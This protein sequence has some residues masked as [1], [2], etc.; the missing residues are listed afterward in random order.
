R[1]ARPPKREAAPGP[2][3]ER[4]RRAPNQDATPVEKPPAGAEYHWRRLP[5]LP[6]PCGSSAP[7]A[8][9]LRCPIIRWILSSHRLAGTP[10]C[11]LSPVGAAEPPN[12]V[13]RSG[14]TL[15]CPPRINYPFALRPSAP[16]GA[17]A[18]PRRGESGNHRRPTDS[19]RAVFARS[20]HTRN[21]WVGG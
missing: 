9:G 12:R 10:S 18:S 21:G 8:L 14:P 3:L 13:R 6:S 11:A 4:F 16:V 5:P 1:S 2:P 20:R 19:H 7:P 15:P 17:H